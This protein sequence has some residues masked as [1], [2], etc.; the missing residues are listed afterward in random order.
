[1]SRRKKRATGLAEISA[2]SG[3]LFARFA[4]LL[5]HFPKAAHGGVDTGAGKV[6]RQKKPLN[7]GAKQVLQ[8]TSCLQGELHP[9]GI[10]R[11]D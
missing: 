9:G 8:A 10:R 6:L 11:A 3:L 4:L 5:T 7:R 1:M 2:S